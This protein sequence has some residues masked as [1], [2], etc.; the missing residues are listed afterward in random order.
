MKTW[1]TTLSIAVW[2]AIAPALSAAAGDTTPIL[3]P[4]EYKNLRLGLWELTDETSTQGGPKI[5]TAQMQSKMAEG[6]KDMTPAQRAQVEELMRKQ[7][8]R[9]SGAPVT[10]TKQQC[11]TAAE[12]DKNLSKGLND[13]NDG[14]VQCTTKEVS[15]TSS[16]VVVEMACTGRDKGQLAKAEG[17]G[18][19]PTAMSQNSTL[20]FEVKSATE[21]ESRFLMSAMLGSQPMKSDMK[22]HGRWLAA[23]CGKTK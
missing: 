5:D 11:I 9:S 22:M 10:H 12:R 13:R 8:A 3:P 18:D 7:A 17:R 23:D 1:K 4:S 2:C 21:F 16:K 14:S 19:G 15:R 6:M 20:S